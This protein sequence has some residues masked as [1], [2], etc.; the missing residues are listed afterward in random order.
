MATMSISSAAEIRVA[1]QRLL[2]E[3]NLTKIIGQPSNTSVD[4]LDAEIAAAVC[5]PVLPSL[6][7]AILK[8]LAVWASF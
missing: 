1:V 8:Y 4:K 5:Y 7:S 3:S 2:E 6:L